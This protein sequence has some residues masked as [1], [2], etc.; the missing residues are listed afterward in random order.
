MVATAEAVD[1]LRRDLPNSCCICS[2][3]TQPGRAVVISDAF[4]L[5]MPT[6]EAWWQLGSW[7][8]DT[9]DRAPALMLVLAVLIAL[10]PLAIVG[11]MMRRKRTGR[12]ILPC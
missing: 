12:P 3:H 4:T 5:A 8:G 9:F 2:G 10:P 7:F 1:C 6:A 11:L